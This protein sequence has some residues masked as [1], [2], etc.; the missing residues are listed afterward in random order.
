[1][2]TWK[3]S[4]SVYGRTANSDGGANSWRIV[5]DTST[6]AW[7]PNRCHA[8]RCV[9]ARCTSAGSSATA[10]RLSA[11]CTSGQR[12]ATQHGGCAHRRASGWT[13]RP[14]ARRALHATVGSHATAVSVDTGRTVAHSPPRRGLL[15]ATRRRRRVGSGTQGIAQLGQHRGVH[16]VALV[17]LLRVARQHARVG[18]RLG[19]HR[20]RTHCRLDVRPVRPRAAHQAGRVP[21]R[22]RAHAAVRPTRRRH[23]AALATASV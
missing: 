3:T 8:G 9:L 14:P 2:Y 21:E 1:M 20:C 10:A 15:L 16:Q 23:R 11:W 7:S 13:L 19:P 5:R 6:A 4:R 12:T 18:Q 17:M 22:R